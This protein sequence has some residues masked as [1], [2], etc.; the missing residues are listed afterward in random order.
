MPLRLP[1]SV[2]FVSYSST[3]RGRVIESSS[4]ER[5]DHGESS[6]EGVLLKHVLVLVVL[7]SRP[8]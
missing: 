2:S 4:L 8:H 3:S 5:M 6:R 7:L 1:A